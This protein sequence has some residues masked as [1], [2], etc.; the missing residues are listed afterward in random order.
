MR[1]A[2]DELD[3]LRWPRGPVPGG[4]WQ[5][6]VDLYRCGSGWFVKFDLAGVRPEDLDIQLTGTTIRVTGTR[7]DWHVHGRQEAHLMEI[8]YSHFQRVVELPARID[9][10]ELRT[11][12]RDGMLLVYVSPRAD[13]R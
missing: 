11:E 1:D 3:L 5:P 2:F 13:Q 12:Y 7:R 6:A 4:A 10:A 9:A 8:A